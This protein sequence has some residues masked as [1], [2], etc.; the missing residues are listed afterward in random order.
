MLV[1]YLIGEGLWRIFVALRNSPAAGHLWLLLSGALS[2]L[3]GFLIWRPWPLAGTSARGILV[4]V[5]VV[6]TG[7]ALVLVAE[8]MGRCKKQS[9]WLQ[10]ATPERDGETRPSQRLG[11]EGI[12]ACNL[13]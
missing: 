6:S 5:N 13:P 1:I 7:V 2:L 9:S 4:G 3:V 12:A 8:S 11:L 10:M